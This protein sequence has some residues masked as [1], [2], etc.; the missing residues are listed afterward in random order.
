VT[1]L[2]FY[3]VLPAFVEVVS[4]WPRLVHLHV[5]WLFIMLATEA[6][7]F[8]CAISLLRLVL[9]TRL[10]FSVAA[11]LLAGNAATNVLP[12][13]VVAGVGVQ[14]Q[15]LAIGGVDADQAAVGLAASSILGLAG[16]FMLPIFALPVILAGS[17]V[18]SGL[19]HTAFL[20]MGLFLLTIVVGA[21]LLTTDR[22]LEVAADFLQWLSNSIPR[23]KARTVNLKVRLVEQRDLVR[24]ELGRQW[25]QAVLLM[26]GRLGLDFCALLAALRA[27]GAR[28]S[29]SLVLLAYAASDAI[30]LIPLTPG[31]LGVVEASLSGLLVLAG[32]PSAAAVV[33]TLA[34]RL[35]TYWLPTVA[36]GAVYLAFR[37]RYGPMQL[38]TGARRTAS[39]PDTPHSAK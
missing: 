27:T 12:A 36:G 6:A 33:A 10:W 16:I 18:S 7:S 1:G 13:G 29:P 26:S 31:G 23:R 15:M 19:V 20:G 8:V 2:A 11:A 3:I 34:Y 25:W 30:A 22:A 5:T 24:G 9:R 4:A 21:V 35:A 28:P 39:P 17:P 32:V 37:R 14:Y 38:G